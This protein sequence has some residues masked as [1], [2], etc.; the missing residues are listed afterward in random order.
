MLLCYTSLIMKWANLHTKDGR[1]RPEHGFTIVELL[2]V[3]VVIAI[4]AAITIVSYGGITGQAKDAVRKQ[5]SRQIET[6]LHLYGQAT[7]NL[8]GAGSNCGRH[9]AGGGWLNRGSAVDPNPAHPE[10]P[11]AIID[12]LADKGVINVG[13]VDPSG[14][15]GFSMESPDGQYS[16]MKYNCNAAAS[17]AF[18]FIKFE[19]QKQGD[20]MDTAGICEGVVDTYGVTARGAYD[21]Y[22]MNYYVKVAL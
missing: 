19:T 14:N 18:I 9:G 12:C 4:L 11:R 5:H 7:G 2:V 20:R 10:Y 8:I 6:A 22:K 13:L 16:Y 15:Y 17:V 21:N 3:I 1:T